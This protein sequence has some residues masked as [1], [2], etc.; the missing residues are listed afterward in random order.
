MGKEVWEVTVWEA[1]VEAL[2]KEGVG[3]GLKCQQLLTWR[4]KSPMKVMVLVGKVST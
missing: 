3:R 1:D 2:E 4:V